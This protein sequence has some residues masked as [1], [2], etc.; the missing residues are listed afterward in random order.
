MIF[1]DM[2]ELIS[3]L[4]KEGELVRVKKEVDGGYEIASVIWELY[5]RLYTDAPAVLFERIKGHSIPVV[6]NIFGSLKRWALILGLPN[7]RDIGPGKDLRDLFLEKLYRE[8]EWVD[9]VL[10]SDGPCKEIIIKGA[11]VD[12]KKLP[13]FQLHPTDGGPYITLPGVIM[14]DPEW[15]R[16]LGMYR[17]MVHDEKTTGLMAMQFQ[18]AGVFCSRARQRGEKTIPVAV[19]IGFDP[20]L[21]LAAV[22]KMPIVGRDSEFRFIGALTGKPVELVK[23]ETVDLEVPAS[24]EIVLEGELHLE[25]TRIEGPFGEYTG[26]YGEKMYLPVFKI[27]CITMRKNPYYI[28]CTSAHAASEC[29]RLHFSQSLKWYTKMKSEISG[30]RDLYIPMEGRLYVAIVQIKKRFPGWGHQALM[31]A[32]SSGWAMSMVNCVIVVDEDIDIYDWKQVLWA[33]ATRVDPELDVII[34]KPVATNALNPAARQR[35]TKSPETGY[36]D[37]N[38]CSKMGI[39]ATKKFEVEPGRKRPTPAVSSPD[40]KTLAMVKAHWAQYGLP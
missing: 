8:D 5:E 17:M 30:F 6:K 28:S 16:N 23:C 14:K 9:P 12:L 29:L 36:T 27:G 13:I 35:L 32:I 34:T 1:N 11:D 37:F 21:H 26:Y 2:R 22:T 7:W 31:T 24:S 39:D 19:A 33:I 38:I 10:L 15:G 25:E 3:R 18:D 40:Q 20:A 4:E